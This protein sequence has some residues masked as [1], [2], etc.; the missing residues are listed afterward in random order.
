MESTDAAYRGLGSMVVRITLAIPLIVAG[1]G[2]LLGVGPKA[3]GIDGF[4]GMLAGMG[5]PA[6]ELAAWAVGSIELVGGLLILIGLFTRMAAVLAAV[7]MAAATVFVHV[8]NGF[9][10]GDG[11]FEYTLVLALI[12][13]SLV[14]SGPGALSLERAVFGRELL[15]G[16]FAGRIVGSR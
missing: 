15:T 10:A 6:P 9:V 8:P 4:A 5:V 3:S 1:A 14:I 16:A 7:V 2:K 13:V 11:G 12:A